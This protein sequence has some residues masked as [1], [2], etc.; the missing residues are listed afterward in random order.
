MAYTF[1]LSDDSYHY[2]NVKTKNITT[3]MHIVLAKSRE[4]QPPNITSGRL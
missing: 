2:K 1:K 4:L 3:E